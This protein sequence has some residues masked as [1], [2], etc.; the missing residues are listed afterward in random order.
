MQLQHQ[1]QAA[2]TDVHLVAT[3]V[4]ADGSLSVLLCSKPISAL[5]NTRKRSCSSAKQEQLKH[6]NMWTSLNTDERDRV[7]TLY[8]Q[9]ELTTV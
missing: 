8:S 1:Q 5:S 3:S 7:I 9:H 2:E 6:I 4:T